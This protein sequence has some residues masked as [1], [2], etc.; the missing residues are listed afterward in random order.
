MSK[1]CTKCVTKKEVS[2][3]YS[4]RADCKVCNLARQTAHRHKNKDKYNQYKRKY[5]IF[6]KYNLTEY[7][8]KELIKSQNN[9]CA[10]CGINAEDVRYKTLCI[11]HNHTTQKV[12]GLLCPTCN[13][14]LGLFQ[15]STEVLE[16]ALDYLHG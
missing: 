12:R 2:E 9:C 10:I 15:D 4:G 13:R 14:G 11:D 6:N 7:E 8:Y 3:F 16:K 1:T 5:K